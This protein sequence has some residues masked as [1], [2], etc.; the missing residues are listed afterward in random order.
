MSAEVWLPVVGWEQTHHVSNRG[1]VKSLSRDVATRWGPNTRPTPERLLSFKVTEYGHHAVTLCAAG[2]RKMAHVH[3]LVLEA[4]VGPPPSASHVC[5]HNDGDPANN[6]PA[7]LRW[8]TVRDNAQD[9]L[10]HGRNAQAN[11]VACKRGHL[12]DEANTYIAR[13]GGRYCRAC[14]AAAAR[15]LRAG[16]R[17][18]QGLALAD[19]GAVAR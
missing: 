13:N 11:K 15:A 14:R 16:F 17:G 19:L 12:F 1:R 10:K 2:S 5:C 8:G 4:F 18:R 3:R 9:C 7:N 6:T